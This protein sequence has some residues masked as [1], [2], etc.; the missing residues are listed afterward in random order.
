MPLE[1]INPE[2][3]TTPEAF[4][5]VIVAK[6]SRMVF[7]AGQVAEDSAGN[8][9]GTGNMVAQSRQVFANIGR[10]LEAAGARP[11]QVTKLTIFVANYRREHLAMIEEGRVSLFGGHK[12]TDTLVGV[13]ALTN[14][15]YMLEVDAIAVIGDDPIG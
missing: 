11:D 3:I 13:A 2:G 14:P 1:C 6:G 12:P 10:A 5:H 8:L 4:T 7:I 9:I 15:D